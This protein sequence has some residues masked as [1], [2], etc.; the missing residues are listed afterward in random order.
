[1]VK[2]KFSRKNM[3][4]SICLDY[5]RPQPQS[6]GSLYT[7]TPVQRGNVGSRSGV[8]SFYYTVEQKVIAD[9]DLLA[10]AARAM[11]K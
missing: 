5:V 9:E 8:P 6:K 10:K 1:M 2:I 4:L 11:Q 3:P 7:A